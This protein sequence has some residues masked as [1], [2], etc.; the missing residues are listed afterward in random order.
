MVHNA[1]ICQL[2]GIILMKV[3][4]VSFVINV[5]AFFRFEKNMSWSDN[6]GTIYQKA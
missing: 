3:S 6:Y 2:K 1:I 4:A 5:A